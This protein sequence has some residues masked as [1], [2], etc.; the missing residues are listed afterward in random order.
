MNKLW[1][2]LF[3]F[4]LFYALAT[5]NFESMIGLLFDVPNKT[6]Q[7][8]LTIGGLI[9][10]YTGIFQMAVESGVIAFVGRIFKPV[11]YLLFPKIPKEHELHDYICGN[12]TANLLGL[13]LASTPIALKTIQELKNYQKATVAT[14]EM[15]TLLVMNITSFSLF[16]LTVLTL[17]EKYHSLLGLKIWI[18][19]IAIT[20]VTSLVALLL[21][22][23]FQR[24]NKWRI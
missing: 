15:I 4:C 6:M 5:K 24:V 18:S 16:P 22:K 19:L 9:I 21:D 8:L 2:F 23:A 11:S 17:R 20:L 1:M 13:G 3:V 14:N 7:M 12:I 10:I